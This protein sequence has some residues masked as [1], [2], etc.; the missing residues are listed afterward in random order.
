MNIIFSW[1]LM[2]SVFSAC[3]MQDT[4]SIQTLD[5]EDLGLTTLFVYEDETEK[6]QLPEQSHE[7]LQQEMTTREKQEA[8]H[9]VAKCSPKKSWFSSFASRSEDEM[10]EDCLGALENEEPIAQPEMEKAVDRPSTS[11]LAWLSFGYLGK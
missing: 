1:L 3:A 8:G 4:Q 2:V 6:K 5:Q 9:P 7:T 11:W 10:L